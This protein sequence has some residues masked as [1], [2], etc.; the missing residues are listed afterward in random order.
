MSTIRLAALAI[1]LSFATLTV[2]ADPGDWLIRAGATY[3]DPVDDGGNLDGTSLEFEVDTAT[4]MTFDVTYM[5]D[6]TLPSNCWRPGR[7]STIS[8]WSHW[9]RSV[10]PSNCRQR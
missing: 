9:A 1:T 4:S 5:L 8:N 6:E 2:S 7:S 10:K 3:I